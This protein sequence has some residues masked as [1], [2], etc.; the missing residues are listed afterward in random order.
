MPRLPSSR[1]PS[2]Q[3]QSVFRP[4][5]GADYVKP[6]V[7]LRKLAADMQADEA[8][9]QEAVLKFN[10]KMEEARLYNQTK[11]AET[12]YKV[13]AEKLD[14]EF[15]L[16]PDAYEPGDY[17]EMLGKIRDKYADTLPDS[18]T[19]EIF[20]RDSELDFTKRIITNRHLRSKKIYENGRSN[21]EQTLKQTR[22]DAPI[23]RQA[24]IFKALSD[25]ISYGY[26]TPDEANKLMQNALM[27][28]AIYDAELPGEVEYVDENGKTKTISQAEFVLRQL[29]DPND[30]TYPLDIDKKQKAF[31]AVAAIT[32]RNKRI[33]AITK[34][35]KEKIDPLDAIRENI[36]TSELTYAQ[37]YNAILNLRLPKEKET[38]AINMLENMQDVLKTTDADTLAFY[39][40]EITALKDKAEKAVSSDKAAVEF[41]ESIA[42]LKESIMGDLGIKIGMANYQSLM[43]NLDKRTTVMYDQ[44]SNGVLAKGDV[45]GWFEFN[46][47]NK[48]ALNE[49]RAAG[50]KK[51]NEMFADYHRLK[52]EIE[53]GD[54]DAVKLFEQEA[55]RKWDGKKADAIELVRIVKK[56]RAEQD[57]AKKEE[58]LATFDITKQA[59]SPK[60]KDDK[61]VWRVTE[62]EQATI[63]ALGYT[64]KQIL[65]YAKKYGFTP[66]EVIEQAKAKKKQAKAKKN[67]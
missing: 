62:E 54:E 43:R 40:D 23:H 41:L 5:E 36:E 3:S 6:S 66:Q 50:R 29:A 18:G 48:Q 63:K 14:E 59:T 37:K 16:N 52:E 25:A 17:E 51:G 47:T 35:K 65:D 67:G 4:V 53:S 33:A 10:T 57:R 12:G 24:E 46:Y 42:A 22:M 7:D 2:Y 49:F 27:D 56:N 30:K 32:R 28:G 26:Y 8:K 11:A 44:L 1:L 38:K 45:G 15:S 13:E 31:N 21:T 19:Q 34:V 39:Q 58:I 61:N 55:K 64:K 20:Y 60:P 9:R